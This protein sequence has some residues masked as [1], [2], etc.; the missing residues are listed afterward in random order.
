MY[1][2]GETEA[3]VGEMAPSAKR[4]SVLIVNSLYAPFVVGGAEVVAEMLA[5]M[6]AAQGQRVS[7]VSSCS[8]EDGVRVERRGGVDLYHFF[9]DNRWWLYERFLPGDRRSTI[10]LVRWRLRDA[11]NRDAGRKFQ[12]VLRR[13]RPDVVHTH[14]IKGFSPIIWH[15]ARRNGIPVVHTA[16]SYELI[17]AN[18]SLLDGSGNSCASQSRCSTCRVHGAWYRAKAAA[19]DVFCSPSQYLL[20]THADAGVPLRRV[21]LVRNGV[22]RP[23]SSPRS[24]RRRLDG[25]IRYL[26]MGQLAAHKGIDTLIEAIGLSSGAALT[27]DIAGRGDGQGKLEALARR[28]D[29]VRFHGFVEGHRKEQLLA[30]ADVLIFPSIWVENAPMSIAEAF[31]FGLPVIGSRIG[32]VPEFVE[33]GSNGLL[34]EPGNARAL[35]ARMVELS[36]RPDMLVRLQQG[37]SESGVSWPTPEAMAAKYLAVYRSLQGRLS[38]E[39]RHGAER[40]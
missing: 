31:C 12:D 33:P 26:Y 2:D 21:A 9:P 39:L 22:N 25:R 11:W 35:A 36:E 32:A 14:N 20:R 5:N 24:P 40:L 19:I 1:L 16:H 6:L 13:V 18:G 27:V 10:D 8:R 30:E 23:T 17:C 15:A 7:V 3:A 34:F 4:L 28:D 29:R 38:D 37:A